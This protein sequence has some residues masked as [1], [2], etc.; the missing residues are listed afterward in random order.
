M[1]SMSGLVQGLKISMI[2]AIGAAVIAMIFGLM[3]KTLEDPKV[4]AK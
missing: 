3:L 1:I 2:L 4:E